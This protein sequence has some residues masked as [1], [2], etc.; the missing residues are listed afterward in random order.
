MN[1]NSKWAFEEKI[2][3]V[4]AL[5]KAVAQDRLKSDTIVFT[6]GCFDLLHLGHLEVI[7]QSR[8]F[9]D[10]LIIGLNSDAS[11]KQLKGP[12]R[13]IQNQVTRASVLAA[14][15]MVDYV[16]LFDTETPLEIIKA[17]QPDVLVKG[18]DY[19]IDQIVG[20][21]VVMS[22]GGR[23]EII[24]ILPGHSTTSTISKMS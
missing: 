10:K 5:K 14:L 13:P 3:T 4:E 18:G 12:S 7:R 9:G 21:D 8:S 15:A 11:V 24:D 1:N 6:N 20:A 19:T 22:Y 17:L 23:V 2:K 16:V